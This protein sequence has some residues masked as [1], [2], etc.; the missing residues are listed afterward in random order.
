MPVV[1]HMLLLLQ[2]CISFAVL[3]PVLTAPQKSADYS[4]D[5]GPCG[6]MHSMGVCEL[7]PRVHPTC[8]LQNGRHT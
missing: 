1:T 3:C 5:T 2:P 7:L 4:L 6:T 8:A